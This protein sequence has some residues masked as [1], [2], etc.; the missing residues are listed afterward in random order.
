MSFFTFFDKIKK[1]VAG[2]L[3]LTVLLSTVYFSFPQK[4]DAQWAVFDGITEFFQGLAYPATYGTDVSSAATAGATISNLALSVAGHVKTFLLDPLAMML[5]KIIIQ[6]ITA[7]TV[8]WINSGF[9][10]NPAFVQ[11]PEQFFTNV[12]DQTAATY[13][14]TA[15]PAWTNFV[16]S[17][18]SAKIRLALVQNYLSTKTPNTCTI[19]SIVKNWTN[20]GTNFYNNG[21]W[22]G[23]FSMTQSDQNNPV[24]SYLQQKDALSIQIGNRQLHYQNQLTQGNGFLSWE[25]CNP[26]PPT[27]GPSLA[28]LGAPASAGAG[29]AS[30]LTAAECA[31]MA[32]G[33]PGCPTG[34]TYPTPANTGPVDTSSTGQTANCPYGTQVNTPGSVIAT[35]LG[36][37]IGSPLQQLGVAQSI[38]QIVG[39][40]MVQMVKS[41]V[42]GF[43]TG[44]LSGLSQSSSGTQSLQQQLEVNATTSSPQFQAVENQIT[45]TEQTVIGQSS[46]GATTTMSSAPIITLVGDG[47]PNKPLEWAVGTPWVDPGYSAS[48]AV[49]GDITSK[50]VITIPGSNLNI[51]DVNTPGVYELDYNVSNSQGIMAT[52]AIRMV[53][54]GNTIVMPTSSTTTTS[55]SGTTVSP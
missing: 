45:N 33:T 52:P 50:V 54:V 35:Q 38:N 26:K 34:S 47:S 13:L 21:G 29:T 40:L 16:C 17:P 32:A 11:N 25:T 48:D 39:A 37:T 6:D 30:T 51:P 1:H 12:G 41:V 53:D 19:Q 42:G 49:D 36:I 23:W 46:A 20:F 18:F 9:N 10:G 15:N 22:D 27:Y 5:A 7:A 31:E 14:S 28:Q 8:K 3:I 4:A 44:G 24:G 43:G 55:T 2:V